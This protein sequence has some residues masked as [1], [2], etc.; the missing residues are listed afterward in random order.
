MSDK[1]QFT[2]VALNVP[3]TLSHSGQ[4]VDIIVSDVSL[5]G[6]KLLAEEGH[7]AKLPFDSHFPYTATFQANAD[8][9]EISLHIE[10]LYRHSDGRTDYVSLGCKVD[11]I[12]IESVSALRRLITLNSADTHIDEK[13]INA[14]INAL[15]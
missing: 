12:D 14:L 8:S 6:I 1:R 13:E 4:N 10:Q 15:Y 11:K 7:L 9:P 5:H 3:G 2:R